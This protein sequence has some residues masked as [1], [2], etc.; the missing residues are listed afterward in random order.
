MTKKFHCWVKWIFVFFERI[1]A[2]RT[3]IQAVTKEQNY[4]VMMSW[5]YERDRKELENVLESTRDATTTTTR[6]VD[7]R[8]NNIKRIKE[9]TA[10]NRADQT[11]MNLWTFYR[12]PSAAF[13]C[14]FAFFYSFKFLF[15]W[16]EWGRPA[17]LPDSNVHLI[18][19]G[20]ISYGIRQLLHL[21]LYSSQFHI[22]G[23]KDNKTKKQKREKENCQVDCCS[24]HIICRVASVLYS[25]RS[26]RMNH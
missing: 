13:V 25:F 18:H 21:C 16:I 7:W 15:V 17:T 14:L 2:Y 6:D 22:G 1:W 8:N 5:F 4:F 10:Y 26:E 20:G 23:K 3:T 11:T 9:M 19:V 24:L 12:Y